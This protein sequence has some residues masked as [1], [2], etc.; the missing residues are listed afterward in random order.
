MS[1]R[2]REVPDRPLAADEVLVH[3]ELYSEEQTLGDGPAPRRVREGG[4][5]FGRVIVHPLE[6]DDF[7]E[8]VRRR[9]AVRTRAF[10]LLEF[11]FDL[12]ELAAARRYTLARYRVELNTPD[13]VATSLWPELVTT[14]VE[15]ERSRSFG[16]QADLTLGALAGAPSAEFSAGHTFRYAEL[17]PLVT[18]F[19]TGQSAFS[20]T[21]TAQEGQPLF[22]S[23][24]RVFAVVD[25]PAGTPAVLGTFVAEV[26]V[27]RR[28]LG[29][30][31]SLSIPPARRPFRLQLTDGSV[32][33][34]SLGEG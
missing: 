18:S 12:D 11:P 33:L 30:W 20:W 19:G 25:V 10:A 21:F 17:R 32:T 31:T 2:F 8:L 13:A 28:K 29:V 6:L 22:P 23:G 9:P 3:D 16:L 34:R 27:S 24:R 26:V 7:P 4:V 1:D 5:S 15:V 14:T